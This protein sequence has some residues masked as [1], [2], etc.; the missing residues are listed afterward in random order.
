MTGEKQI[1]LDFLS[2]AGTER[3][4]VLVTGILTVMREREVRLITFFL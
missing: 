3:V 2:F 4:T 1:T